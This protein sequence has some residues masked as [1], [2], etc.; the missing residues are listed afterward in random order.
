VLV[1]LELIALVL[2]QL[3]LAV[4]MAVVTFNLQMVAFLVVQAAQVVAVLLLLPKVA[5]ELLDKDLQVA[6]A[7]LT[8]SLAVVVVVLVLLVELL[9]VKVALAVQASS[10]QLMEPQ[11]STQV[12]AAVA[13]PM[14][15]VVKAVCFL[16]MAVM[17]AA[18][19]VVL[20]V[21]MAVDL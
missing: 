4:V 1:Y 13:D 9:L 12:V 6:A 11:L 19:R 8:H 5:V 16:E 20:V 10:H 21:Q 15:L 17:A 14:N 7:V 18:V 3:R 2:A